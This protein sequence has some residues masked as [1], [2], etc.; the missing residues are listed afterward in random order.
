MSWLEDLIASQYLKTPEIINA[1]TR[2]K[3]GH[4]MLPGDEDKAEI[5]AP[6]P[7]GYGQTI[8]QPLTVAFMLELLKPQSGEKVLDVGS[9]SGWTVALL[10]D[11]VGSAGRVYGLEIL[12]PL[13]KMAI[14]NVSKYNFISQGIAY[15][16]QGDGYQG[17]LTAAPFDKIIVAAAAPTVP[18]VLLNQLKIGGRIVIP[19]GREYRTQT[20][21]VMD[22]ITTE[23]YKEA[24]FPGFIFVP[25]VKN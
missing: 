19:I 20:M 18:S 10:A 11:I 14:T 7:I 22:K 4:F 17:L 2:V 8:S 9:G 21:V 24:R 23:K 15:I 6:I 1:F 16:T 25:L 13:V 12:L 5:N 3:R